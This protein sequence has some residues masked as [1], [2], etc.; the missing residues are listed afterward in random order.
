MMKSN[1]NSSQEVQDISRELFIV[2]MA[3]Y[4]HHN[5]FL[6]QQLP[7]E[8]HTSKFNNSTPTQQQHDT[9]TTLKQR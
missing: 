4:Q 5:I 6:G 3:H 8:Q 2:Q 1:K 7:T 9:N